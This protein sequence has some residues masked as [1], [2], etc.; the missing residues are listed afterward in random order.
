MLFNHGYPSLAA[1]RKKKTDG[2]LCRTILWLSK[3][4]PSILKEKGPESCLHNL[5]RFIL[6]YICV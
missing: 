3:R 6:V 2:S 5:I 1:K 4:I